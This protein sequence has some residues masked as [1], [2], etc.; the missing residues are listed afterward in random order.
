MV[1]GSQLKVD[2]KK[3]IGCGTCIVSYEKLFKFDS[4]GKSE[5]IASGKCGD[6]EINEVVDIC[7]Q[8][9]ISKKS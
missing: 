1:K 5:P 9:A 7:P 8:N 4:Q 3:C 2:K 6:C